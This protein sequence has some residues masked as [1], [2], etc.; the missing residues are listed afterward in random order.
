MGMKRF[1]MLTGDNPITAHAVAK[2]LGIEEVHAELLP[3]DKVAEVKK[4]QQANHKVAFIGDGINDAP[5]LALADIRD[6]D[7]DM[8]QMLQL[9]HLISTNAL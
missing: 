1:V 6:C 2:Q 9:K 8:A 5:S 3:A 4:L 7:R